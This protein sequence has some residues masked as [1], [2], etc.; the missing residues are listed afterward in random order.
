MSEVINEVVPLAVEQDA[1]EMED[2]LSPVAAPAHPRTIEPHA[3]EVAH[4]PLDGAAADVEVVAT[5]IVVAQ[6]VLVL[7]E[8]LG[9]LE[10]LRS[11]R[12]GAGA[13]LRDALVGARQLV[14]NTVG[15]AAPTELSGTSCHPTC[16]VGR[17]FWVQASTGVPELLGDVVP[18]EARLGVGEDARLQLP[19][20]LGAVG[21]EQRALGPVATLLGFDLEPGE[22]RGVT[23][24]G[25][26]QALGDWALATLV[27]GAQRVDHT[28]EG[29]LGVL[30]L[31]A[32]LAARTDAVAAAT[33]TPVASSAVAWL[34]WLSPAFALGRIDH[35]YAAAIDLDDEDVAVI[36]RRRSGLEEPTRLG[37]DRVDHAQDRALA[38]RPLAEAVKGRARGGERH[39]RGQPR[40][41]DHGAEA[42]A[43]HQA[44]RAIDRQIARTATTIGAPPARPREGNLAETCPDLGAGGT[45]R[46]QDEVHTLVSVLHR[47]W[48]RSLP[49]QEQRDGAASQREHCGPQLLLDDCERARSVGVGNRL[50]TRACPLDVAAQHLHTR[51]RGSSRRVSR[52]GRGD[53]CRERAPLRNSAHVSDRDSS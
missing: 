20:R 30:A 13:G 51:H 40:H 5:E 37:A 15:A 21:N 18:V 26:A 47:P 23:F 50:H 28:D 6:A 41:G 53:I 29:D 35:R 45:P 38:R 46:I 31:V 32:L 2:M 24:E 12:F 25:G 7:G 33:A 43:T 27:G 11:L 36:G 19:D 14:E 4:R 48:P 42:E 3:D 16:Q 1:A 39:L 9:D 34:A 10:D 49:R 22:Q 8:M 44:Q 52:L 17:A